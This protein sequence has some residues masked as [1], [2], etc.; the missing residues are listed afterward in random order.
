MTIF[1]INHIP[2]IQNSIIIRYWCFRGNSSVFGKLLFAGN[3]SIVDSILRRIVWCL[4]RRGTIIFHR[5]RWNHLVEAGFFR[6]RVIRSNF[7]CIRFLI[8]VFINMIILVRNWTVLLDISS[9]L[10]LCVVLLRFGFPNLL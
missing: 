10:A 6:M 5:K 7:N 9:W 3:G 1:Q 2:F 4:W 8:A